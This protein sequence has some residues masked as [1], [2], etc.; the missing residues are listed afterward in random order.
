MARTAA[1]KQSRPGEK[2][3]EVWRD[4]DVE[5]SGPVVSELEKLY[6]QHWAEQQAPSL[7]EGAQP[8]Q[9]ESQGQE[10]V[11]IVG[12]SPSRSTSPYYVTVLSAIRNA[13]RTLW[14]TAAYFVPTH[15]EKVDLMRAA[16]RGIDVRLILPSHSDSPPALAVQHSHYTDLLTAGVKI[17]ERD[18]EVLHS[19]TMVIDTVWSI[20]G[21][22]NFDQRSVLFNDEVDAVIIGQNTGKQ[23]EKIFQDDQ[24][25]AR[26]IEL[27]DWKRRSVGA[28]NARAILAA[29]AEIA[30]KKHAAGA[31]AAATRQRGS[32]MLR[33]YQNSIT[34]PAP[35]TRAFSSTKCAAARSCGAIPKDL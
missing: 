7:V 34:S 8:T 11:R 1:A 26:S 24:Q 28:K 35:D 14:I 25:H 9:L 4:I 2:P 18:D 22:S 5:I 30:I 16:R 32:T 3:A 19:K 21:S 6:A 12:S 10:V 13:E 23:L 27:A 33:G 20:T 31:C 29:L 15:Q 17:Y